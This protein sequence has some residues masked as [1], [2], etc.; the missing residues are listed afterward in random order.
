MVQFSR[1]P[2]GCAY[3]RQPGD[4]RAHQT[5]GNDCQ[6]DSHFSRFG[7]NGGVRVNSIVN[8]QHNSQATL[9]GRQCRETNTMNCK[10][11]RN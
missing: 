10:V 1:K 5:F 3:V 8:I 6:D 4:A 9:Q 7:L 2:P 11:Q